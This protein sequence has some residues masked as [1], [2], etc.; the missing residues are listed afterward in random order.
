MSN[1]KILVIEDDAD[2]RLGYKVLLEAY[3]YQTFF[4]ADSSAALNELSEHPPDLIV[5]DLGLPGRDGFF[6]L[7]EI[8]MYVHMA[9]LIVVSARQPHGNAEQVLSLGAKAYVQKPWNDDEL[10]E[11]IRGLLFE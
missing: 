11:L 2:V 9:P 3:G 7:D 8:G 5:L 10:L 4:A 1:E 6:V